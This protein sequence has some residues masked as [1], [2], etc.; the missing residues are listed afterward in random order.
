MSIQLNEEA[1]PVLLAPEV[2]VSRD[3]TRESLCHAIASVATVYGLPFPFLAN[4]IHQESTFRWHVVS[5]AG[6]QGIAQF[7]PRTAQAYGLYNPFDPIHSLSVSGQFLSELF[8]QFGN[9]GLA[10]AAYNAG[11]SRVRNFVRNGSRLPQETQNYVRIITGRTV[12]QWRGV[13]GDPAVAMPTKAG[14]PTPTPSEPQAI[15]SADA[16]FDLDDQ[17]AIATTN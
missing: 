1:V 3:Y 15:A 9:V 7:M 12:A 8:D 17:I 16:D 10:A 11:P 13:K 5:P 4:L 14:C 2:T 6:A